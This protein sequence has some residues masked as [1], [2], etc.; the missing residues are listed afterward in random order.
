MVKSK[1]IKKMIWTHGWV[2]FPVI[3]GRPLHY[4][5]KGNKF[6][7]EVVK[8]IIALEANH[9][10]VEGEEKTYYIQFFADEAES[11]KQ[12]RRKRAGSR[13]GLKFLFLLFQ[14]NK[15]R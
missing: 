4:Y 15:K 1:K 5:W 8:K 9:I 6:Q 12:Q 3:T 11:L 13:R 10:V 2:V 7:T 14:K